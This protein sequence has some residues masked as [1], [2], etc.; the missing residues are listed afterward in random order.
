[1]ATTNTDSALRYFT[2]EASDLRASAAENRAWATEAEAMGNKDAA[3][4]YAA[5]ADAAEVEALRHER[6]LAQMA[7]DGAIWF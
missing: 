7:D 3:R 2:K 5:W 1:M 4:D 6:T